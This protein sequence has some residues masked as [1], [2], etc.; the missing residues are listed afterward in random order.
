MNIIVRQPGSGTTVNLFTAL[1]K[2][3]ATFESKANL[4]NSV[5]EFS[6]LTNKISVNTNQD[7]L[8]FVSFL[9]YSIGYMY[10]P[11]VERASLVKIALMQ[12]SNNI[13][14]EA[15]KKSILASMQQIMS[16]PES[17]LTL[18]RHISDSGSLEA[19]PIVAFSFYFFQK[20][21]YV[22]SGNQTQSDRILWSLRYLYWTLT[23]GTSDG[24]AQIDS[25]QNEIRPSRDIF[26]KQPSA[27][28]SAEML[29]F[30]PISDAFRSYSKNFL[31]AA[32]LNNKPIYSN[33]PCNLPQSNNLTDTQSGCFND[34]YCVLQEAFQPMTT[35]E[36]PAIKSIAPYCC[37]VILFG[38]F[39]G[40]IGSFAWI[41]IPTN[42]ICKTRLFFP[43]IAFGLVFGLV[44]LLMLFMKSYRI[45]VIFG[46]KQIRLQDS[47]MPNSKLILT[48]VLLTLVE[49][50]L[51]GAWV[52][53]AQ[54]EA[55][56]P[57]NG[58]GI[59]TGCSAKP[60]NESI[61]LIFQF[62]LYGLNGSLLVSCVYIAFRTRRAFERFLESKTI[63]MSIYTVVISIAICIS[64]VYAFPR[65]IE[66]WYYVTSFVLSITMNV[67]SLLVSLIIFGPRLLDVIQLRFNP[68]STEQV[69]TQ[70]H[71]DTRFSIGIIDV[72]SELVESGKD[73]KSVENLSIQAVKF[74]IGIRQIKFGS[75]WVESDLVILPEI[76]M[77]IIFR[78]FRKQIIHSIFKFGSLEISSNLASYDT[79]LE[80]VA[81]Q[82]QKAA[83]SD[84][85]ETDNINEEKRFLLSSGSM[86]TLGVFLLQFSSKRAKDDF[87]KIVDMIKNV[88]SQSSIHMP[89][90]PSFNTGIGPGQEFF[91]KTQGDIPLAVL[92][93]MRDEISMKRTMS[94]TFLTASSSS[95]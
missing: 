26:I 3:D 7:V 18:N 13:T 62:L 23:S 19:Y 88:D 66:S 44:V 75:R 24:I 31:E 2:F 12:N 59:Q 73:R 17:P 92:S 32:S 29:S 9:P 82:F 8:T 30:V 76:Q 21:N 20:N 85:S 64:V 65:D 86:P 90:T 35:K 37:Y 48:T 89:D 43:P 10:N 41:I 45:Y 39:C 46:Y 67:C 50:I 84:V 52:G 33:T 80:K 71:I 28:L 70:S 58:S 4:N 49:I 42:G 91:G 60:G 40:L 94:E 69:T 74:E 36:A 77:M 54:H 68:G 63:G 81:R 34:S 14:V 57:I 16:T 56:T 55:V 22:F 78:D 47:S 6:W 87:K 38:C 93:M 95:S 27:K 1:T 25:L 83:A 15:N 72:N 53:F 5:K 51:V 61:D 11:E 79:T